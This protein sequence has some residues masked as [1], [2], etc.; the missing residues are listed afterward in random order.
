MSLAPLTRVAETMLIKGLKLGLG[1][2][3]QLVVLDGFRMNVGKV[4]LIRILL[5]LGIKR[6]ALGLLLGILLDR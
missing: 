4:E 3:L 5:R 1:Y 6:V 2:Q